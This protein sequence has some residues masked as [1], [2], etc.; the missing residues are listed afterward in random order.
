MSVA[1]WLKN[2]STEFRKVCTSVQGAHRHRGSLTSVH[3]TESLTS[4]P[5]TYWLPKFPSMCHES[6]AD[7][8]KEL[9]PV[10]AGKGYISFYGVLSGRG[11]M[12]K[13]AGTFVG[14]R[15]PL[16]LKQIMFTRIASRHKACDNASPMSY[17]CVLSALV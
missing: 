10:A 13:E 16:T 1:I 3:N 8:V 2:S 11:N 15:L 7:I 4:M 14:V 9:R 17:A 6:W 5:S 12:T